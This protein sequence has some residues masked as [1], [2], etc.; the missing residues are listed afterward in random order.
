MV[1]KKESILPQERIQVKTFLVAV[2]ILTAVL[3]KADVCHADVYSVTARWVVECVLIGKG[4]DGLEVNVM[5]NDHA[6]VKAFKAMRDTI[7]KS[8]MAAKKVHFYVTPSSLDCQ[9]MEEYLRAAKIPYIKY[10]IEA[11]R[12]AR[13]RYE[14]AGGTGIPFLVIGDAI[15]E[16][17]D[18]DRVKDAWE[19]WN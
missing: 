2:A 17:Y 7:Y 16:G 5:V 9:R 13:E 10:D 18:P 3:F 6:L 19:W 11:D 8:G 15:V 4:E 14:A 1:P 12:L